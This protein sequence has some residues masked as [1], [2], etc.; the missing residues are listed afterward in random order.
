MLPSFTFTFSL[1]SLSLS[2][3]LYFLLS[4]YLPLPDI[5]S[6]LPDLLTYYQPYLSGHYTKL[7]TFNFGIIFILIFFFIFY[8]LLKFFQKLSVKHS[9]SF[10][11]LNIFAFIISIASF[12]FLIYENIGYLKVYRSIFTLD[13]HLF[14]PGFLLSLLL[15]ILLLVYLLRL[16]SNSTYHPEGVTESLLPGERM[17][18]SKYK[19]FLLFSLLAI[20]IFVTLFDRTMDEK[21]LFVAWTRQYT[22]SAIFIQPIYD[23]LNGKAVLAN[24]DSMYGVFVGLVPAIIF[25]FIP[26]TFT[27]FFYLSI[28]FGILY[29]LC[30]AIL[31]RFRTGSFFWTFISLAMLFSLHFYPL[32]DRY[33]RPMIFP[34]RYLLDIPFFLLLFIQHKR[35]Q[36]YAVFLSLFLAFAVFYNFETGIALVIS[37]FVYCILKVCD[38]S[39]I[40]F[41][42]VIQTM[43]KK[44]FIFICAFIFIGFIYSLYAKS[45]TGIFP[46]W[47]RMLFY[48][49]IF[50]AG[51]TPDIP[52]SLYLLPAIIYLVT[53]IRTGFL[54]IKRKVEHFTAWD[55]G[56]SVYGLIILSNYISRSYIINLIAV[57]IPAIIMAV[58]HFKDLCSYLYSRKKTIYDLPLIACYLILGSFIVFSLVYYAY[59]LPQNPHIDYWRGDKIASR[60]LLEK[61]DD[62]TLL[63]GKYLPASK[64]ITLLSFFDT[65][66]LLRTAKVNTLPYGTSQNILT[67]FQSEEVARSILK[68]Y[69][70]FI[71]ADSDALLRDNI[72]QDAYLYLNQ[73]YEKIESKGILDVWKRIK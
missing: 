62:S 63:I 65:L 21:N 6:K 18:N 48:V 37:Y 26:L 20:M 8:Y 54:L 13:P 73:N 28:A 69:P 17:F 32:L 4:R 60:Q 55:A 53:L 22:H 36:K 41:T 42:E 52:Q 3:F 72:Y 39:K 43:L 27:N 25:K 45:V 15:G 59:R 38:N 7:L 23:L 57:G 61:I 46:D 10:K 12:I 19:Q 40:S 9:L 51:Q 11:A 66:L 56:L 50:G 29:Y 47:T 30:I 2:F 31:V 71:F 64:N 24:T 14:S 58:I 35:N 1:I 68:D 44:I 49:R 34:L 33:L 16:T 70:Q 67:K 5:T